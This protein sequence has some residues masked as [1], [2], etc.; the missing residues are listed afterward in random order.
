MASA[1]HSADYSISCGHPMAELGRAWFHVA[2]NGPFLMRNLHQEWAIRQ[3]VI[4][5]YTAPASLYANHINGEFGT[6]D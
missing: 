1:A 4:T 5:F 2:V 6:P 3:Q